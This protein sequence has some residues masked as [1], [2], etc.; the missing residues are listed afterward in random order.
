MIRICTLAL[1]AV[2]MPAQEQP[3]FTTGV[4]VVNVLAT[5]RNKKGA[6]VRDLGQDD[7][8]VAEN[9]RPQT[10]R[11]FSRQTDL[12]LTL[13]LMIDT[14]MSQKRVMEAERIASY[15]FL[16][17]I[18]REKKDQVFIM[19]FDLSPI[20][21]QELTSSFLKLSEA[22]QRVDTPN[23]NDLRSQTGGGTMLYDAL[24][25]AC[26][27][28]MAPQ[29][30][31]K[32]LIVLTDGVD[33]GSEKTLADTIEAAQ[34]ADTLIYAIL[35]SDEGFYGAFGGGDGR[36]VLARM[37]RETGGGF[38]EVSKR[39]SLDDIYTQL[40]EELRSQYNIGYVSDQPA[41]ISEFRKI[42]LTTRQKGLTVQARSRYW[43]QR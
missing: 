1:L 2:L 35:F 8:S 10:I 13:G 12:P 38:F 21:R 3:T 39:Q 4:K 5:V 34:K 43:A 19:Q 28:I 42:Q 32:A 27:E 26:R 15:T 17:Q 33:T 11:Y 16:E 40:Q 36:G 22:L 25:K 14:S 18:L 23:I 29:T 37:S 7:F 31:R 20:L 41:S 24:V 6:F 9:G 30:G